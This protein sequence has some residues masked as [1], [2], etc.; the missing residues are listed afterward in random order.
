MPTTYTSMFDAPS[1]ITKKEMCALL[2]L[3]ATRPG[4]TFSAT[5]IK[6]AYYKRSLRFHPDK[7]SSY[8]HP[9]PEEICNVLM[10]DI[11]L[12][13]DYLSNGEDNIPGKAFL[14]R[15]QQSFTSETTD[16]L[17]FAIITLKAIETGSSNLS[18]VVPWISFLSRSYFITIALS[19]FSDGQLNF[20]YVNI[21]ADQ[22]N[23]LKPIMSHIDGSSVV[24]ILRSIKEGLQLT[25]QE[26]FAD[27]LQTLKPQLAQYI[28]DEERF[29]ALISAIKDAREELSI[30][31]TDNFI[32]HIQRIITFL[33]NFIATVP[34]WKHILQVYFTSLIIT[35]NSLP[36]FFNAL[37][38]IAD[39]IL[40]QKGA[41][42]LALAALPLTVLTA[43]LL[44]I[45]IAVQLSTQMGWI[46]LK[47]IVNIVTNAI[48]LMSSTAALLYAGDFSYKNIFSIIEATFNLVIRTAITSTLEALNSAIFIL[49]NQN[50]ISPVLSQ[51]DR[52][53]DSVIHYLRPKTNVHTNDAAADQ[54]EYQLIPYDEEQQ[55]QQ[56]SAER[57]NQSARFFAHPV[58]PLFNDEDLWLN[59]L[60]DNLSQDHDDTDVEQD[61]VRYTSAA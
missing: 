2:N 22:L 4:L 39:V 60:L 30:M 14:S 50:L 40:K 6:K 23:S 55:Q 36:K 27:F 31:L 45:N 57:S 5:E 17:E 13:R 33:P 10:N 8:P 32:N 38:V 56:D 20:R 9:I 37:T 28:G 59:Q 1:I 18:R 44:P 35:S 7:Q 49:T 19:T 58:L 47:A 15:A 25:E 41:L 53:L 24:R 51:I 43:M 16:W 46:A 26:E 34:S 29:E 52:F 11:A 61:D 21:L 48:R 12:A 54:S 3:D 42:A